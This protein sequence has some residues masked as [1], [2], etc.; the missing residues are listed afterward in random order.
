ME[1]IAVS[2]YE[3]FNRNIGSRE[4]FNQRDA[5][6]EVGDNWRDLGFASDLHISFKNNR[7]KRPLIPFTFRDIV[8]RAGMFY[9][10][11]NEF[12]GWRVIGPPR[13]SVLPRNPES[14]I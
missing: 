8:I 5:L 10:Y 12:P 7:F 1:P 3:C 4:L 13:P 9:H 11:Q 6:S 14:K 2:L